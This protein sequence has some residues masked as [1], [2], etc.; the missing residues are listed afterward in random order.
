M[1]CLLNMNIIKP[2]RI[3]LPY[4]FLHRSLKKV[5]FGWSIPVWAIMCD[6]PQEFD[7]KGETKLTTRWSYPPTHVRI[8][9]WKAL[10]II[11]I[12]SCLMQKWQHLAWWW[13]SLIIRYAINPILCIKK[14]SK[15]LILLTKPWHCQQVRGT[16]GFTVLQHRD[17]FF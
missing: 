1:H 13:F 16:W 12:T 15:I 5:P 8:T 10:L 7:A 17:F 6:P 3:R 4:P 11:W 2:E 9:R 14:G